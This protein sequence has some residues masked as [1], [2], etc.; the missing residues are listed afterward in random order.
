ML[1]R[2]GAG[3]FYGKS[4]RL[5]LIEFLRAEKKFDNFSALK[6]QIYADID[7]AT[8]LAADTST[9]SNSILEV[10]FSFLNCNA[11]SSIE[12]AEK[13]SLEILPV[14]DNKG[15]PCLWRKINQGEST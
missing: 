3:D 6:S 10:L 14:D 1:G 13:F 7:I 12:L 8:T 5:G 4:M 11:T 9:H 15:R 2:D